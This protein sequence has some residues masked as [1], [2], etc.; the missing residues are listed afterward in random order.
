MRILLAAF[1]TFEC[2]PSTFLQID[3]LTIFV[4]KVV[5]VG[6]EDANLPFLLYLQGGPG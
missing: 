4:R 6:K 2:S 5:A 1:V 3:Y